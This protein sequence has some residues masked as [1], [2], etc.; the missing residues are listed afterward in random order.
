MALVDYFD[1]IS[2]TDCRKYL[3]EFYCRFVESSCREENE[4]EDADKYFFFFTHTE[5]LF[6]ASWIISNRR[7]NQIMKKTYKL[8][9]QKPNEK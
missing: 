2:L 1:C 6:E 5:M 4:L 8:L 9:A 3:W 7:M